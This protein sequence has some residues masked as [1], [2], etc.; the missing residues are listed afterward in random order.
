V[1]PTQSRTRPGA[2]S[3]SVA[4]AIAMCTGCMAWGLTASSVTPTRAVAPSTTAATVNGSRR[5]RW[6]D[7]HTVSAPASSAARACSRST[8]SGLRPS[9]ATP[10]EGVTGIGRL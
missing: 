3:S 6:L 7:T 8:A 10:S 9:K 1:V 2:S 4:A 5:N